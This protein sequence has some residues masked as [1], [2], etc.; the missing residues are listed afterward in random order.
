VEE[1]A[2][3]ES[4]MKKILLVDDAPYV[5]CMSSAEMGILGGRISGEFLP[6]MMVL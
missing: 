1:L 6:Q 2:M 4:Q 3:T 5:C